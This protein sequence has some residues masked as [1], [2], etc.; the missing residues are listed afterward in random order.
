[1]YNNNGNYEY[2]ALILSTALSGLYGQAEQGEYFRTF[3]GM[4]K[5]QENVFLYFEIRLNSCRF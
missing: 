1:M 3:Y 2:L 5:K 4:T